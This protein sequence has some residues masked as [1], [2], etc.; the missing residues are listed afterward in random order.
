MNFTDDALKTILSSLPNNYNDNW[1]DIRFGKQ[2]KSTQNFLKSKIQ[3]QL[4][5][6]GYYHITAIQHLLS[7]ALQLYEFEYLYDHLELIED[8]KLLLQVLAYRILGY[9]KVKLPLNTRDYRE[10][11][12]F[13]ESLA[14]K[15]DSIN[16]NFLHYF[17]FKMDLR[18]IGYPI[19]FYFTVGGVMTGFIVKQ[20]EY[21]KNGI[22]IKA[23]KDDVV[24]DGGGC[25]GD[26]ALF[27][28]NEV[29][30]GGKVFSF[31]FIPNNIK[32]FEKNISLNEDLK[33]SVELVRSPLWNNSTTKIH[34]KDFGPGSTVSLNGFSGSDGE[35]ITVSIDDIVAKRA[36]NRIDF[37]K[38]DIEGA[39]TSALQGASQTIKKFK[40]KLAVALYHDPSDFKQIPQ[41]LKNLVPEY[42]FYFSH[43][44]IHGEESMLFAKAD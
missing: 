17:L 31:E 14:D 11:L 19:Q 15:S 13:V 3:K 43:A 34:F 6:K 40:P 36:I 33:A 27:F 39:E 16:P 18:K 42:K 23:V 32:I 5:K 44:T 22:L 29:G 41:F 7:N 30:A 37:I 9:R 10:K 8:K 35:C 1:D 26:T 4:R 2:Q 28:A 38:L 20:Y 21:N 12:K 25:W 24:I